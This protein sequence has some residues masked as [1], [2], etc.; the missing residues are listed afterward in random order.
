MWRYYYSLKELGFA[1]WLDEPDIAAGAN[2][3][4]ELIRGFDESC[5]VVFFF[6]TEHF[7]DEKYLDTEIDYAIQQKRKK[8]KKFAII[9]L[10]HPDADDVPSLLT[11]YI[12]K[13]VDNDL[14]GF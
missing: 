8:G 13:T 3:E 10:R 12:Y 7:T 1:P 5:A 4:R 9:T 6:M 14:A 2:L 11:P